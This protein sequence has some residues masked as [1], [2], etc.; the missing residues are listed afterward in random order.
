LDPLAL[1]QRGL[2][3][4]SPSTAV[5][6]SGAARVAGRDCYVLTLT[7]HSPDTL[8]GRVEVSIDA[9]RRLPLR[10][11]AFARGAGKPALSVGFTS[12][13]FDPVDPSIYRFSP[14]PGAK[15][16][17]AP[18]SPAHAGWSGPPGQTGEPAVGSAGQYGGGPGALGAI[19]T[20]GHDWATVVAVRIPML[21]QALGAAGGLDLH[22]FLP[23]TGPL[24]SVR[25]VQRGDHDWL[26]YGFV[27][28]SALAA[29]D[30]QLT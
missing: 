18:A 19:R 11:A 29:V 26:V 24:F 22:S 20:F 30:G 23:F 10:T 8:I 13:S 21:P 4:L 14:P 7:P 1:A 5:A 12:V 3:A 25:L 15:V 17:P 16:V 28:Q 6:V 27:P 9:E 2:A